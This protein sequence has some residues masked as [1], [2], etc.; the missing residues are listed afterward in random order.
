MG[1]GPGGGPG[2]GMDGGPGGG[3]D[4][5]P[6]GGFANGGQPPAFDSAQF[7]QRMMDQIRTSLNVT[8]AD[9]WSAIQPLVQKVM[10]ARREASSGM[11]FGMFGPGGPGGPG[12]DANRSATQQRFGPKL[13]AEAEALQN[14]VTQNA[15]V[16]QLKDALAKC[17]AA[18]A[19]KQA[20]LQAAQD[21][22]QK[23][24]TFKQEAEA[25]L[26]GLLH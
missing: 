10:D 24:L 23:V 26:L 8:N 9:D 19:D 11:G 1:G 6:G 2:G 13:S 15:S 17:R 4:G 16:A 22:L 14:L 21:N 18:H 5:G 7:Q 12:G 3:M 25:M 20:Q